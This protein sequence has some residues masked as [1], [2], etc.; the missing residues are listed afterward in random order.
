LI[1][2][3]IAIIATLGGLCFAPAIVKEMTEYVR[4]I[5]VGTNIPCL[6][7]GAALP[8]DRDEAAVDL[9]LRGS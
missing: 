9:V 1:A 8:C 4:L 7:L 2:F 6:E 3:N 5:Q